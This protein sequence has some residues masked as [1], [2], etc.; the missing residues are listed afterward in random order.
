LPADEAMAAWRSWRWAGASKAQRLAVSVPSHCALLDK[1]AAALAR[2]PRQ[3]A[4]PA[5]RLFERLDGARAVGSAADRRRS[6]DEHGAPGALAGGDDRR[7]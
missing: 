2:L 6:G 4:A 3:L 5:L 7:R 1:P